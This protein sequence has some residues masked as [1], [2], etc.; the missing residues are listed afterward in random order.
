MQSLKLLGTSNYGFPDEAVLA[1]RQSARMAVDHFVLFRQPKTMRH[2][3]PQ[4]LIR[5]CPSHEP[6]MDESTMYELGTNSAIIPPC[7]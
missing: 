1:S 5:A 6:T 3:I 7:Q 4:S 2:A